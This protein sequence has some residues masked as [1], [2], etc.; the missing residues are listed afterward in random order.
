MVSIFI[1]THSH[2]TLFKSNDS[3]EGPNQSYFKS[4]YVKELL[5]EQD[6]MNEAFQKSMESLRIAFQWHQFNDENKWENVVQDIEQI[7]D[8]TRQHEEMDKKMR[9]WLMMLEHNS[10]ELHRV[11]RENSTLNQDVLKEVHRIHQS[12]EEIMD[13]LMQFD[14]ANEQFSGR[15]TE[16]ANN[17]QVM[18][19]YVA[20]QHDKQDKVLDQLENQGALMEKSNRQLTNLRSILYER[21]GFIADKIEESYKLTTSILYKFLTGTDQPLT[22][23]MTNQ[24]K[25]ANKHND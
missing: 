18:A 5:E 2:P 25:E 13:K 1:N 11:V 22:L 8:K 24:K 19:E 16:I 9:E 20:D 21:S 4:D 12:N 10:E 14:A 17:Q 15:M 23:M 3:K 6:Q 7:R